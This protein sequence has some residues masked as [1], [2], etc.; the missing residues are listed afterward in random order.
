[1][2]CPT[3]DQRDL[4]ILWRGVVNLQTD[5]L[6]LVRFYAD[7]LSVAFKLVPSTLSEW[8][9]KAVG[10]LRFLG[11]SDGPAQAPGIEAMPAL[12]KELLG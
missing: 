3:C 6:G 7:A 1:V 8:I 10:L 11:C 5:N 9:D 2:K 12:F 4:R